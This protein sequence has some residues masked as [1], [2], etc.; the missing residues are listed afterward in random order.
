VNI[1]YATLY[2]GLLGV[3]YRYN[4][5]FLLSVWNV[6]NPSRIALLK[7]IKFNV[8]YRSS[9]SSPAPVSITID[10]QFIVVQGYVFVPKRPRKGIKPKHRKEQ[11]NKPP[12]VVAHFI[13]TRTLEVIRLL[14]VDA[15]MAVCHKGL[16]FILINERVQIYDVSSGIFYRNLILHE[17]SDSVDSLEF[18]VSVNS[19]YVAILY[20]AKSERNR[21]KTMLRLYEVEAL[22]NVDAEPNNLLLTTIENDGPLSMMM[23]ETRMAICNVLCNESNKGAVFVLDFSP[24]QTQ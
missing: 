22:K 3:L 11:L 16:L 21:W 1:E 15:E 9:L 2:N 12:V 18:Q 7:K 19:K 10:E 6:E 8:R 24:R 14:T 4:G 23:D 5:R 20:S 17:N 13:S